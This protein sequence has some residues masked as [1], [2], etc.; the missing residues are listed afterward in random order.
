MTFNMFLPQIRRHHPVGV[1][2]GVRLCRLEEKD[3]ARAHRARATDSYQ[4][5]YALLSAQ[6]SFHI[7][8]RACITAVG[9]NLNGNHV[10]PLVQLA[11]GN[12]H[13]NRACLSQ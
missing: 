9:V 5:V 12:N 3:V 6:N 4:Q 7:E 2:T 11:S 13:G 8:S 1:N 10:L